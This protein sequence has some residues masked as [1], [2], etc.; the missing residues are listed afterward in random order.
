VTSSNQQRGSP[1]RAWR[2]STYAWSSSTELQWA[3]RQRG[4]DPRGTRVG[5]QRNRRVGRG[6]P[7][8]SRIGT[9]SGRALRQRVIPPRKMGMDADFFSAWP[10]RFMLPTIIR[11]WRPEPDPGEVDCLPTRSRQPIPAPPG[12]RRGGS[13]ARERRRPSRTPIPPKPRSAGLPSHRFRRCSCQGS[14]NPAYPRCITGAGLTMQQSSP[15]RKRW[16]LRP[17]RT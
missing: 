14:G 10:M 9:S 3:A 16:L 5:G 15:R 2:R 8:R 7:V 17:T 11:P 13:P 4:A 12:A 6:W 1:P